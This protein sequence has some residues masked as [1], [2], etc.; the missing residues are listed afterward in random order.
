M[1]VLPE[2]LLSMGRC[3]VLAQPMSE[4]SLVAGTPVGGHDQVGQGVAI[5]T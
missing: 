4:V 2:S 5:W 1:R 3:R